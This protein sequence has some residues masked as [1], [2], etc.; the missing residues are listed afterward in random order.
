MPFLLDRTR[1][2]LCPEMSNADLTSKKERSSHRPLQLQQ[3]LLR[4]YQT[5][6]QSTYVQ[7]QLQ[8][9]LF[10]P[11][12]GLLQVCIDQKQNYSTTVNLVRERICHVKR[13]PSWRS[14]RAMLHLLFWAVQAANLSRTKCLLQNKNA[15][16]PNDR[17][18][19]KILLYFRQGLCS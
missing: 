15:H 3:N 1:C 12:P 7:M 14:S 17:Q 8:M 5:M 6:R 10:D 11:S 18:Y 16:N 9:S 19:C 2:K 13:W 4:L